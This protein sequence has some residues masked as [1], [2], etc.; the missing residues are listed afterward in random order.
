M[1]V[2][3]LRRLSDWILDRFI[4]LDTTLDATDDE[5]NEWEA[6]KG[7]I[8]RDKDAYMHVF[9]HNLDYPNAKIA[10]ARELSE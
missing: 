1:E 7:I 2:V 3:M 10:Y 9:T 5:I 4:P 6:R 8:R